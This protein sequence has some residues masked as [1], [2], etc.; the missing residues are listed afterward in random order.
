MKFNDL[1]ISANKSST[2][3]G[4]GISAGKGKTAGRGTK[5]QN[6]RSGSKRR[7]SFE[8][9]QMPLIQMIPKLPGFKSL[10]KPNF[11]L[12]TAKLEE[13]QEKEITNQLLAKLH[14]IKRQDYPVR[15][16]VKGEL[17]SA[18][19]VKLQGASETAKSA[20]I[21]AGGTV[22]VQSRTAKPE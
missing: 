16:V 10:R 6:S 13:I 4:R 7:R 19:N 2:R 8:G 12:T 9:G 5:G 3:K 14:I 22:R 21:A 1:D 15:V 17:K 11:T 20:I 18:K